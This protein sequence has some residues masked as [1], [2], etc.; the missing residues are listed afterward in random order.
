TARLVAA[1]GLLSASA[2]GKRMGKDDCTR[3]NPCVHVG[4]GRYLTSLCVAGGPSLRR[5]LR[6]VAWLAGVGD[7]RFV[8]LRARACAL[9]L[10][11]CW[12]V[13]GE[14]WVAHPRETRTQAGASCRVSAERS[15]PALDRL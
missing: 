11:R 4:L 3:P 2:M 6:G 1:R 9:R 13:R 10:A 7:L 8:E 12:R 14:G 15:R 5:G